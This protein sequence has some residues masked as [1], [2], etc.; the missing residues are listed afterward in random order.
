MSCLFHNEARTEKGSQLNSLG[1]EII[2]MIGLKMMTTNLGLRGC[3][4]LPPAFVAEA[5]KLGR[6]TVAVTLA[7]YSINEF[8]QDFLPI[9]SSRILRKTGIRD[10]YDAFKYNVLPQ[11]LSSLD[12]VFDA[13]IDTKDAQTILMGSGLARRKLNESVHFEYV[14]RKYDNSKMCTD[15]ESDFAKIPKILAE[16]VAK[17]VDKSRLKTA[18]AQGCK[19][20]GVQP[21]TG[22]QCPPISVAAKCGA[23]HAAKL[24][25]YAVEL[26]DRI[27]SYGPRNY[28]EA[29]LHLEEI[30]G[31]RRNS[32]QFYQVAQLLERLNSSTHAGER[33]VSLLPDCAGPGMIP[34]TLAMSADVRIRKLATKLGQDV[35][36]DVVEQAQDADSDDEDEM[37]MVQTTAKA[38]AK[39][40]YEKLLDDIIVKQVYGRTVG[41]VYVIEYQ[42]R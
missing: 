3:D 14:L 28:L 34:L 23:S 31:L 15:C 13:V 5:F 27:S 17:G 7:Q 38:S 19:E 33:L 8:V 42:K 11:S 2:T 10:W 39:D 4:C 22:Y 37:Q 12:V 24:A 32:F 9:T 21:R 20:L 29:S 40:E 25:A 18:F 26:R 16:M 6:K 35:D 30:I 1:Y 41:R 36:G